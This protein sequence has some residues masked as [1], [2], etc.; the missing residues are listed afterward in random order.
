MRRVRLRAGTLL[1]VGMFALGAL[2]TGAMYGYWARQVGPFR[3]LTDALA[4]EYPGSSPRVT[5]GRWRLN[6]ERDTTLL[7]V[8]KVP[9]DP[10]RAPTQ[11]NVHARTVAGFVAAR[12][13]LTP[14]RIVAVHLFHPQ[15]EGTL[16]QAT[17]RLPVDEI[18]PVGQNRLHTLTP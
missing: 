14:Y 7:V 12:F 18:T 6:P 3:G 11:L 5:A 10:Q 4:A 2:L 17:V 15:P 16:S 13:D 9:F 8:L 1:V